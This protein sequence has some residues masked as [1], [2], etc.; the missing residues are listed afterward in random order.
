MSP[1]TSD[2]IVKMPPRITVSRVG[3][4]E[5]TSPIQ[6]KCESYLDVRKHPLE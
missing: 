2:A 5:K 6:S 4:S 1:K 3:I